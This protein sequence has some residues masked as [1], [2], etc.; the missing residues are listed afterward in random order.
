[1]NIPRL[2]QLD[3]NQTLVTIGPRQYYFSYQ[4]CIA[5][6][7]FTDGRKYRSANS[8]S[9]T[10]AKHMGQMGVKDWPQLSEEQFAE[11]IAK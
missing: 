8:Y 2:T 3:S 6:Q 9:V 10:T 11:E 5:F 7:D 4:T 1:M